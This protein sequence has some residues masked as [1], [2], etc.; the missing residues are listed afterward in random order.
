MATLRRVEQQ[1]AAT[2]ADALGEVRLDG[3][4]DAQVLEAIALAAGIGR[5]AEVLVAEAT[6]IVQR[7]S[8]SPV[9][10]ERLTTRVGCASVNELLQRTTRCARRTAS[11]YERAA[12]AV[13]RPTSLSTGERLPAEYP[14]LRSAMSAGA[15]GI[16]GLSAVLGP[17]S[18]VPAAA[19]RAAFLA[20]D[21]ELAASAA[22]T[23]V[24]AEPPACAEDLR[25][26][27][28][29]WAIHLD[30]D[31]T[32][33]REAR[34]QRKRG[35]TFGPPSDG[36]VAIRGHLLADVFA[37]FQTLFDAILNPKLAGPRFTG[38]EDGDGCERRD[39]GGEA[40]GGCESGGGDG[41]EGGGRCALAD[42]RTRAQK[43]HD[44]L[45]T[46]LGVAAASGGLPEIGGSA[47][48]LVVSIRAEDVESGSGYA[49]AQ[50]CEEP[51]PL[52]VAR[53]IA[54]S[55]RVQR[56]VFDPAGRILS[57]GTTRRT[58]NRAQ[59]RAILARDGGCI[60]P[61]CHVPA[62]WCE[63]HHVE[64]HARGGPTHTDNGV[65]LCWWHHR[66]LDSSGWRIRMNQG[67]PE[68]RGPSWW[69]SPGVWRPV[70]KAR[71]RLVDRLQARR[72]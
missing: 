32:E 8:A 37:Q 46:V 31:G 11:R 52:G 33:P 54:C 15:I 70:T 6:G 34:A 55:G 5:L 23:G 12:R 38:D 36:V 14:G 1:L 29:V 27:A 67:A 10:E 19:G 24:T 42:S 4:D 56:V 25:M 48:T 18:G 64:E 58:F 39:E 16:D 17:L 7:R 21:E 26:Q 61:G 51:L 13:H 72:T 49:H 50:G 45:A 71:G 35:L 57:I 9:R 62:A 40:K 41:R 65:P 22:G 53:Q 3:A 60:I 68:V 47:P 20:A 30:Q 44:V 28:Q 63:I 66:T 2:V 43:L 59:R 69:D